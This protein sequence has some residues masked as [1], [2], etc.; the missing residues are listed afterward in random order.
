[1][2]PDTNADVLRRH[3][4]DVL[5]CWCENILIAPRY[6]RQSQY[7][8]SVLSAGPSIATSPSGSRE[9]RASS[10]STPRTRPSCPRPTCPSSS[11]YLASLLLSF[12]GINQ[13]FRHRRCHGKCRH[14]RN[15]GRTNP[16]WGVVLGII[17]CWVA[18]RNA[19]AGFV[20]RSRESE[21]DFGPSLPIPN[22][23]YAFFSVAQGVFSFVI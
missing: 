8:A 20:S 14:V 19:F 13:R 4:L 18:L 11:L 22:Y 23:E 10:S 1:M 3:G 16:R 5:A 2:P 9:T 7:W 17:S 15:C 6:A 12:A 21:P